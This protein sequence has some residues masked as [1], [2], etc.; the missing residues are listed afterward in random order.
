[1]PN[2]S[3]T[4]TVVGATGIIGRAIAA[5]LAELGGWRVVG[6]TRSGGIVPGVDE[7]IAVDLRDPEEGRRGLAQAAGTTHLFFAALIQGP[8]R[9]GSP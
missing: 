9:R 4:P 5:K 3:T 2:E 1:M 6:V 8:L 7:A